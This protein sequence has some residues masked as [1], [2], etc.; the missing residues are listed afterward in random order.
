MHKAL[1]DLELF[2]HKRDAIDPIIKAGIMHAQFET[3]HPF[4][5][6]N[7]RTGRI[8]ITLF[9]YLEHILE[10]PVLFLSSYFHKHRHVYYD[11]LSAYHN[12]DIEKWLDFFLDGIIETA[13]NAIETVKA[14]HKLREEDMRKI[15]SL[16]KSVSK[17]SMNVLLELYKNPIINVANIEKIT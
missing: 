3:I 12:N 8:L 7:G 16:G 10:K 15:Q 5:D 2:F 13:E 11:R 4:L 6:G 14:I 9:L 17:I 1:D